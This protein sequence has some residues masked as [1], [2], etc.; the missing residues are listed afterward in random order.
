MGEMTIGKRIGLGFGLVLF[1]LAASNLSNFFSL[2]RVVEN[3]TASIGGNQLDRVLA[4]K[5]IDHLNW[6][7][8]VN[9]FLTDPN[10]NQL[11]VQTDDHKCGLGS[12]LYGEG[13][14]KAAAMVPALAPMIKGLEDPHQR[15]HQSA[16]AIREAYGDTNQGPA[17]AM[18]IFNRDSLP[19]LR[20]IQNKLHRI[21][22]VASDNIISENEMLKAA[23]RGK[24]W[25]I[26]IF[27]LALLI[28][29]GAS[30]LVSSSIIRLLGQTAGEMNLAAG[31]VNVASDQIASSSQALAD[32][33]GQQAAALEETSASMEELGAMTV[34]NTENAGSAEKLIEESSTSMDQA[35][36]FMKRLEESMAEISTASAETQKIIKT[37]D[38]IA[39]Q[40]NLLALNAAVEAARAGEAGAGF[41]VVAEEVR[42]LAMRAGQ[43]AGETSTMIEKTVETVSKGIEV[44]TGT[45]EVFAASLDS[46]KRTTTLISEIAAASRQQ[47]EGIEQSNRA[48]SEI[49][50]V[51]QQNAAAA[52][53]SASAAA[54]L[55]GQAENLDR[56]VKKLLIL[57]G[58]DDTDISAAAGP[59][60]GNA[61]TFAI[62]GKS[63]P[64]IEAF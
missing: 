60:A 6:V 12:W 42:N 46:L 45:G 17:V 22:K 27:I 32:W 50:S 53:E 62:P 33:A 26:A 57:L 2:N 30:W 25:S 54:S 48:I 35:S 51:T 43:A 31:E 7:A 14:K 9:A 58:E 64:A 29:G 23:D 28:G 24:I 41:A 59:A 11:T 47:K 21:R 36:E 16:I 40:T 56:T 18:E 13:S 19:A 4:Q 61:G 38:E 37:I 8:K 3:A 52:E 44:T 15:L 10:I 20:E 5:E 49:D 39:F 55:S 34:Q 63:V 1:L